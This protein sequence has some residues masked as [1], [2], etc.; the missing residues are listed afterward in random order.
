MISNNGSIDIA[1]VSQPLSSFCCR[2]LFRYFSRVRLKKKKSRGCRTENQFAAS[3]IEYLSING[4]P[5][6]RKIKVSAKLFTR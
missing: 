2:Q 3:G 4:G 1:K 5:S 6:K